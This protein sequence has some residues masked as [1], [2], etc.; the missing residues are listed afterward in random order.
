MTLSREKEMWAIA[1]WVEENYGVGGP[2]YIADQIARLAAEDQPDGVSLRLKVAERYEQL[3]G[4][5][6]P[7]FV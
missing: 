6:L 5:E 1:L 4:R 2:T 7:P 3:L